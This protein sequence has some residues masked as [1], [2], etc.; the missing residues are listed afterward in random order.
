[1]NQQNWVT[2]YANWVV[3]HPWRVMLLA[4]L[5]VMSVASGAKHLT[6]SNSYRIFFSA[7]NPQLV[8]FDTLEKS[9]TKND[10]V[11][12]IITPKKGD[13]ISSET[14]EMI[15]QLSNDAWQ[16]PYSIRVDSLTNFQHTEA[17]DDDLIVQDLVMEDEPLDQAALNKIRQVALNE[18]LLVNRLISENA[19]VSG[20][21]VTVHLPGIDEVTEIPE[22]VAFTRDLAQ[23]YRER[24]PDIEI[25]LNGLVFMNNAFARSEERRVGKECRL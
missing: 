17:Y 3:N 9:Y 21:N 18:P 4:I 6:F 20:V 12:F 5:V 1:M 22:V 13:V 23:Q 24:Y 14:L 10:N 16:M 7:D 15:R 8:A 25:R 11:M 19:G 2:C